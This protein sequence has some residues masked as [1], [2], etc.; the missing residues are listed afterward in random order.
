MPKFA[1]LI[2]VWLAL[3]GTV[4]L[5]VRIASPVLATFQNYFFAFAIVIGV[6]QIFSAIAEFSQAKML[7]VFANAGFLFEAVW[8]LVSIW[9]L[10]KAS[11]VAPAWY[12]VSYLMYFSLVIFIAVRTI[13]NDRQ[14]PE[15]TT[16]KG[17]ALAEGVFGTYYSIAGMFIQNGA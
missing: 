1:K 3:A 2:A 15:G 7:L 10:V 4:F 9:Q 11:Q 5:I 6:L 8:V 13:K 16:S 12:S 17:S 14:A